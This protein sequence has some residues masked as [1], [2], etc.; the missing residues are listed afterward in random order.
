MRA[1]APPPALAW[2]TYLARIVLET[3]IFV[4][5]GPVV[6]T[7]VFLVAF[8]ILSRSPGGIVVIAVGFPY[9]FVFGYLLAW[10]AA[11]ATGIVVGALMPYLA[12]ARRVYAVAIVTGIAASLVVVAS[13][14]GALSGHWLALTIAFA[15]AGAAAACTWL[16]LR[17]WQWCGSGASVSG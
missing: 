2:P 3:L 16:G 12:E 14:S 4:G 6:G 17:F 11:V 13:P 1:I 15:G 8:A 7:I 9:V 5:V 10:K